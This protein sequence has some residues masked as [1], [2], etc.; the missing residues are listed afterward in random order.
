MKESLDG[1]C[2]SFK[3]MLFCIFRLQVD[4]QLFVQLVFDLQPQ[5]LILCVY[6][7]GICV[8]FFVGFEPRPS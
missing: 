6:E 8:F 1:R 5:T 7:G 2:A 3:L 4:Y